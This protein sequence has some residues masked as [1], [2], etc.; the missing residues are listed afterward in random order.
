MYLSLSIDMYPLPCIKQIAGGK[1]LY[2]TGAQLG[3]L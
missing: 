1:L 3:G 2:N